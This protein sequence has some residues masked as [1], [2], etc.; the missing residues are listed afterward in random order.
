MLFT[1]ET[2]KYCLLSYA[3]WDKENQDACVADAIPLSGLFNWSLIFNGIRN[4]P[5]TPEGFDNIN[6]LHVNITGN[7]LQ[8]VPKVHQLIDRNKTK[9]L[10]NVDYS[11]CIWGPNFR[12]PTFL[13]REL[14]RADYVFAVE[15]EMAEYLSIAL[16]RNVPCIP[17]PVATHKIKDLRTFKRQTEIGIAVHTYDQA[18]M[19][20][21]LALEIA[22]VDRGRW[23]TTAIGGGIDQRV[24][25]HLFD[26]FVDNIDFVVLM[27]HIAQLFCV[28]ET[29][30]IRSYGRL[31]IEAACLGVPVIGANVVSSQRR[32]FPDLCTEISQPTKT[33]ALLTRLLNDQ[34]F[35]TACA[36]KA[37]A[38]SEYYSFENCKAMMLDFLNGGSGASKKVFDLS[39]IGM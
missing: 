32:L 17:H 28:I 27:K 6:L 16:Q 38:L 35:W 24:E 11:I 3:K 29:Y 22:R 10:Y 31:T 8:L 13:L 26:N 19:T 20:A 1:E 12:F 23:C 33:A 21:A 39:E 5:K 2:I 4:F 7:N 15:E 25:G 30:R 18:F 14:D 36:S 9:L 34:P 37:A